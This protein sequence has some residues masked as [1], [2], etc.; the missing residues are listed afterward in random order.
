MTCALRVTG[1]APNTITVLVDGHVI[2][3]RI[4]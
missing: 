1:V 3:K 4:A 2:R